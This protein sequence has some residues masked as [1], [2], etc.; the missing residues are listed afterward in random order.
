[1]RV[2]TLLFLLLSWQSLAITLVQKN[3]PN[4]QTK[5]STEPGSF[6]IGGYIGKSFYDIDTNL[7]G[8][9]DNKDTS[10]K[11]IAGLQ[12][13][14]FI[15][16]ELGGIDLGTASVDLSSQSSNG[17][18]RIAASSSRSGLITNLNLGLPVTE[19]FSIYGKLGIY[20]WQTDNDVYNNNEEYDS[21]L[22][23]YLDSER[24]TSVF[25]GIGAR[26]TWSHFMFSAEWERYDTEIDNVDVVSIGLLYRF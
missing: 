8:S 23:E 12:F 11:L 24:E 20:S 10:F 15:A 16:W 1:M 21:W 6:Y 14:E 2:F 17:Q 18:Q 26:V 5:K 9:V 13:N 3:H 25:Y 7:A 22:E 19:F 4:Y